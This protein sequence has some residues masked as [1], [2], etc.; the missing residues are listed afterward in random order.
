MAGP[1][2]QFSNR[3]AKISAACSMNLFSNIFMSVALDDKEACAYV[4]RILTGIEDLEILEIRTQERIAKLVD[5][6]VVLDIRACDSKGRIYSIEIQ[7]ADT[8]DH[9]RRVRLYR[10]EIDSHTLAKGTDVDALPELYLIYIS[11]TDIFQSGLAWD[12]VEQ[13]FRRSERRYDDGCHIIFANAEIP[14][15]DPISNLMQY[16]KS[17]DPEDGRHGALSRRIH[18]L[19]REQ[20]G[21]DIMCKVTDSFIQE[22]KRIGKLEDIRT[23]MA[24]Q[25]WDADRTMEFLDIEHAER[26]FYAA[27]LHDRSVPGAPAEV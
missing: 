26:P 25:G 21:K 15:N 12:C 11:E 18:M 17:A 24:K 9:A 3:E 8:L 22:G 13:H 1:F 20:G 10:S 2:L 6:D 16:F 23:I 14:E 27:Y 7:R 19:K 4:I 5:R